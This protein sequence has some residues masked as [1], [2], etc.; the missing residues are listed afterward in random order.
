MGT[1]PFIAAALLY[2]QTWCSS[3]RGRLDSRRLVVRCAISRHLQTT[4][5]Q[6]PQNWTYYHLQHWPNVS[7]PPMR[8]R[9]R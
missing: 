4:A 7:N 1:N 2:N 9:V 6:Y 8:Y 5:P 3:R